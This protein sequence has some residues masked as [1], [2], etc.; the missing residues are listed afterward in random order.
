MWDGT[1]GFKGKVKIKCDNTMSVRD[2]MKNTLKMNSK[3]SFCSLN[4]AIRKYIKELEKEGLEIEIKH[5]KGHQDDLQRF[6]FLSRW[7]QLNVIADGK[8]KNRLANHFHSRNKVR[9]SVYHKEGWTCWLGNN[10]CEDFKHNQL[11]DWI[12]RKR[13]DFTGTGKRR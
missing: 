13:Q 3:Q 6:E 12:F 7:S 10:K 4:R 2:S 1:G 8:A 11:Q 9:I 5:I